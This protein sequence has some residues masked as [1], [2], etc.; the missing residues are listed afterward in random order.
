M[1]GWQT[2]E[3]VVSPSVSFGKALDIARTEEFAEHVRNPRHAILKR[4]GTQLTLIGAKAP[5]E[6][7][8]AEAE[9]GLFLQMRYNT[10]VLFDTGDLAE[11]ADSLV[12]KLRA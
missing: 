4:P 12:E 9:D 10:F 1:W 5:L 11:L 3:R 7:S 2:V 6:L 8:L